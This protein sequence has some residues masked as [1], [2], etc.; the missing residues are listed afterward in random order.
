MKI[1]LTGAEGF[2]GRNFYSMYQ[3]KYHITRYGGDILDM[4]LN[5]FESHYDMVIHLAGLAG[6]RASHEQPEEFW[7]NNV[8]GSRRVFE[9]CEEIKIPVIYASSSSVYEWWL[10]PYATTKKVVEEIAPSRSL[11]LRFHTVYGPDSRPDMLYD[12]VLKRD[13][14]YVTNHARDWTHVEDVCTAIDIC[15]QNWRKI[16]LPVID[17]GNGMPRSVKDMVDHLWPDNNLPERE[18]SGEREYTCAD[19]SVLVQLGWKP[20]HDILTDG[21]V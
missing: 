5:Y 15:I 7:K 18:V 12:R 10:S 3:D 16:D 4:E 17:V 11:G 8:D 2:I 6:V 13:V 19:P 14:S 20:Q 9:Q 1:L 21:I